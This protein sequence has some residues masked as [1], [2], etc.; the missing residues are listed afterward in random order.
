MNVTHAVEGSFER[1]F[2]TKKYLISMELEQQY[3]KAERSCEIVVVRIGKLKTGN[4]LKLKV[5]A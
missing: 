4:V 5:I 3:L 2:A 1:L